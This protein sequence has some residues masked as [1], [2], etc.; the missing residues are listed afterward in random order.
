MM[1]RGKVSAAHLADILGR[2]HPEQFTEA[3]GEIGRIVEANL[4]HHLGY[5]FVPSLK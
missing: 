1:R 2:V 4:V 5:V 3:F